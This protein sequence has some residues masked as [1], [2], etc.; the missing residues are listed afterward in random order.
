[1][2]PPFPGGWLIRGLRVVSFGLTQ[3]YQ[4]QPLVPELLEDGLPH[5]GAPARPVAELLVQPIDG[6]GERNGDRDS[7]ILIQPLTPTSP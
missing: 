1:M 4:L 6:L 3:L 2:S 5:E 7:G